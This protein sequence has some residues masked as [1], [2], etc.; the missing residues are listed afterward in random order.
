MSALH[1][2]AKAWGGDVCGRD[3]LIPGPGHSPTDR[4]LAVRLTDSGFTVY[5]HA[6]DDFAICGDHVKALLGD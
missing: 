5:S 6:N 2:Y 4:S 1:Q 3:I